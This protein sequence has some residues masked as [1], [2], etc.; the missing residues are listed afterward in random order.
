MLQKIKFRVWLEFRACLHEE[1]TKNGGLF[2]SRSEDVTKKT[3]ARQPSGNIT[4]M[5]TLQFTLT[6]TAFAF[7]HVY[8]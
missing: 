8:G 4:A 6:K 5:I 1:W 7:Y 2:A 3:T